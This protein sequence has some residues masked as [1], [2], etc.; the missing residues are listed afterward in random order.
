MSNRH[1]SALMVVMLLVYTWA[2][3]PLASAELSWQKIN[4]CPWEGTDEEGG[5]RIAKYFGFG[6][7]IKKDLLEKIGTGKPDARG[8]IK[9]GDRINAML[10]CRGQIVS[11]VVAAWTDGTETV[12][13]EE[14]TVKSRDGR[15][16]YTVAKPVKRLPQNDDACKNWFLKS[17]DF[18]ISKPE[19]SAPPQA[20]PRPAAAPAIHPTPSTRAAA[21]VAVPEY[22]LIRIRLWKRADDAPARLKGVTGFNS[23]DL[24]GGIRKAATGGKATPGQGPGE[25]ADY[26]VEFIEAT[27]A[28]AWGS[29]FYVN[30]EAW[31]ISEIFTPP[32]TAVTVRVCGGEGTLRVPIGWITPETEVRLFSPW[33]ENRTHYP[34]NGILRSCSVAEVRTGAGNCAK[35]AEYGGGELWWHIQSER[36]KDRTS[37]WHFAK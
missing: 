7:E 21:P 25:C 8:I 18:H 3:V 20:P 24:G 14:Y 11:K 6:E 22:H 35:F 34:A 17:F 15:F 30:G 16:S 26:Q 29:N 5:T 32:Q 33:G 2:F 28:K 27:F 13:T 37:N 19:A 36:A 23:Q 31:P 4:V 10:F 1:A 12:E 9:K